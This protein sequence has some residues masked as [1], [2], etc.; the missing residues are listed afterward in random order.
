MKCLRC[1]SLSSQKEW[2]EYEAPKRNGGEAKI[3]K[4]PSCRDCGDLHRIAF[5]H[6]TFKD[7][8]QA[9]FND[10]GMKA[11]AETAESVRRGRPPDWLTAVLTKYTREF[12][13]L[14]TGVILVSEAE[15]TRKLQ[16]AKLPKH[17]KSIPSIQAPLPLA[18]CKERNLPAGTCETAY[19][20][21][22]SQRP[23]RVARLVVQ[24]G[25]ELKSNIVQQEMYEGHS[26][27]IMGKSVADQHATMNLENLRSQYKKVVALDEF[28]EERMQK[29]KAA[30]DAKAPQSKRAK[31]GESDDEEDEGDDDESDNASEKSEDSGDQN[32]DTDSTDQD[33]DDPDEPGPRSLRPAST[34][35]MKLK[36]GISPAKSILSAPRSSPGLT[37]KSTK[38]SII[39]D[40]TTDILGDDDLID[41]VALQGHAGAIDNYRPRVRCTT[42]GLARINRTVVT[43]RLDA[44]DALGGFQNVSGVIARLRRHALRRRARDGEEAQVALVGGDVGRAQGRVGAKYP[45][46]SAS[47]REVGEDGRGQ[48]LGE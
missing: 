42:L 45:G 38:Q 10:P 20:F 28:V 39:D 41:D 43:I 11:N 48:S 36:P 16:L 17:M 18:V 47:S 7:F 44:F 15:L 26:Q 21:S 5:S 31:V 6:L 12:V 37:R 29:R 14:S 3:A 23:H 8:A 35:Q 24:T 13:E 40:G 27:H 9:C 2:Y 33:N 30:A 22:D 32:S 34:P 1:L 19:C 46:S 25:F 4:G